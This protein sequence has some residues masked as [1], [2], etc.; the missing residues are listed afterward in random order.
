MAEVK[1]QRENTRKKK[2]KAQGENEEN[3]VADELADIDCTE[4]S[5]QPNDCDMVVI[6]RDTDANQNPETSHE[7]HIAEGNEQ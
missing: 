6:D 5:A 3:L 2:A 7:E 1:I 4:E